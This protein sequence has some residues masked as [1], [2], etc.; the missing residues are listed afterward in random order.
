[1]VHRNL[2][3]LGAVTLI[4]A[5][6]LLAHY[7]NASSHHANL[8]GLV[9]ISPVVVAIS[10]VVL[11]ALTFAWRA[12]PRSLM[13]GTVGALCL[14]LWAGWPM[15][16]NHYGLVYW[17]QHMG[18]QLILLMTFGRTLSAGRL[19]LCTRFAEAVHAPLSSRHQ[20][21]AR[22]VT[23]AWTMFFAVM[24]FTST[25]LFFLTP[26][27]TW[28][29]FANFLTLPLVALMFVAEY[30][31]RKWA[32]PEMRH[33]HFLDAVRAFRNVSARSR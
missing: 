7:T 15:L 21:Y 31:V 27:S 8:G 33:A 4:C 12:P 18:M 2:R 25:A 26:L 11:V 5:Y 3:I 20:I 14:A 13:A 16:V 22:Q 17:L 29:V 1:M 30:W 19:P 10:P 23:I 9:A 24:A 28:S 6:A 32:L